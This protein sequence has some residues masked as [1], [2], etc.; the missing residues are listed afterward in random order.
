MI[1]NDDYAGGNATDLEDINPVHDSGAAHDSSWDPHAP[2]TTIVSS[3]AQNTGTATPPSNLS[4][5]MSIDDMQKEMQVAEHE[6]PTKFNVFDKPAD[7]THSPVQPEYVMP[8][9]QAATPVPPKAQYVTPINH[10][11]YDSSDAAWLDIIQ[12]HPELSYL[13]AEIMRLV[14]TKT[15]LPRARA[16]LNRL[17][18]A[19]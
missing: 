2:E 14:C 15:D 7:D 13:Q 17:I 8:P 16:L 11:S 3:A 5:T 12:A 9:V 19:V 4:G 18:A 10:T 6:D 1:K